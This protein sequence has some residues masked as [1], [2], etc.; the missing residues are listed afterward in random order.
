MKLAENLGAK[1]YVFQH[2]DPPSAA[3]TGSLCHTRLD[4]KEL[5]VN[6]LSGQKIVRLR[7]KV[8]NSRGQLDT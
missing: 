7:P 3:L 6:Y 1:T 4:S 8:F 2:N 5:P